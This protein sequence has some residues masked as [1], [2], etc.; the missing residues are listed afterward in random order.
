MFHDG[1]DPGESVGQDSEQSAIAEPGVR[2]YFD[3]AQKHLNLAF[4][5]GGCLPSSA[6]ISRS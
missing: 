4:D 5:E 6:K 2:G 3:R 1:A